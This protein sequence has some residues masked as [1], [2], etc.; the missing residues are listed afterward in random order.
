[1]NYQLTVKDPLDTRLMNYQL[2]VK[3]PLGTRL[4]NYQLT[5][6]DPLCFLGIIRCKSHV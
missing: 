4:M 3:D 5:V 6:K 2:T 1:M